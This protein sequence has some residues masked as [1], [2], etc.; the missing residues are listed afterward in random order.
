[1]VHP[2]VQNM[3]VFGENKRGLKGKVNNADTDSINYFFSKW[4]KDIAKTNLNTHR[5][6]DVEMGKKLSVKHAPVGF[7]K[8]Y[9]SL[10]LSHGFLKT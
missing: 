1:M 8:M 10:I 4:L 3:R 7:T 5:F 9:G 6:K 2:E